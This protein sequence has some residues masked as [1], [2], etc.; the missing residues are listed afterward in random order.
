MII[1]GREKRSAQ[2]L[3]EERSLYEQWVG[4]WENYVKGAQ[5][6][7]ELVAEFDHALFCQRSGGEEVTAWEETAD[8][9]EAF[10]PNVARAQGV[11][12][13]AERCYRMTLQ[14][15]FKNEDVVVSA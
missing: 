13:P 1:V 14:G 7:M 8:P 12:D 4:Q 15:V 9:A 11:V 5:Q 10:M 2:R 3:K 6:V